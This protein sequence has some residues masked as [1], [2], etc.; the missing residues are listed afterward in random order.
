MVINFKRTVVT[1]ALPYV[2][3]MPHLGNLA[4]S[5]LPADIFHRFLDLMGY[6]NIFICGSDQHGTPIELEALQLG[7]KP[8][9]LA[10]KNHLKVYETLKKFDFDFTFYGRTHSPFNEKLTLDF[11]KE[12]YRN[13]Y[14]EEREEENA[15][16]VN[17]KRFLADRYVEGKCYFCNGLAR[18][19][20]CNDCGKLIEPKKLENAYC[21]ICGKKTIKFRK[22]KNL[23]LLLFKFEKELREWIENSDVLPQGIKLEMLNLIKSGLGERPIT[24]DIEWGFKIPY[25]ELGL[26]E[27]YRNKVIYVWFDA[28]IGYIS[29]TMEYFNSIGKEEEWEKYWKSKDSRTTYSIGKDN[30]IFH[31]IIFPSMLIGTKKN[32][33]LPTK[34]F[35]QQFLITKA[36]KFSKSTG[37]GL[38]I[39]K[40]I[41]IL[42]ADYWRFYLAYN[43]PE[44]Q[45]AEFS[46]EHFEE[47]INSEL[48]NIGNF[49]N[50]ALSLCE[51]YF[52]SKLPNINFEKEEHEILEKIEKCKIEYIKEFENYSLKGAFFKALS[53]IKFGDEYLGNKEPWRNEEKR[54]EIIF[55]SIKIANLASL[56]LY[57]FIPNASNKIRDMLNLEKVS[58]KGIDWLENSER[59]IHPGKKLGRREILFRKISKEE[60]QLKLQC[61]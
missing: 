46:L 6:E 31:S 19:D 53:L 7:I 43:L 1:S 36:G 52:N 34:I 9:D 48:L 25:H 38:A 13:G 56:L 61:L 27:E 5:I 60:L 12:L 54:A 24:R 44:K 49:V 22:T 10:E 50:R 2:H 18:G 17:C 23:Y 39:D 11:F 57:P 40:T 35:V 21:K 26:G 8:K 42:P 14:I 28:P 32:Y 30:T 51:N 59:E 29:S 55:I 33:N 41:K 58:N 45:D 37:I 47:V 16:C 15:Y 20:Q 4:G 3:R